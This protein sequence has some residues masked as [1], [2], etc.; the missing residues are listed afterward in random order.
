MSDESANYRYI[1]EYGHDVV[2]TT[3]AEGGKDSYE[4]ATQVETVSTISAI[5]KLYR[6]GFERD[7]SGGVP[8]GDAVFWVKDTVEFPDDATT[9][10]SQLTDDGVDYQVVQIDDQRTGLLAVLVERK[11]PS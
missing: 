5:R 1:D 10:A 3:Y 8:T 4:D 6:G 9:P 7:A 2:L 11:R